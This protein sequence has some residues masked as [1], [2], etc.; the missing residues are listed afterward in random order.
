MRKALIIAFA[1]LAVL[2]GCGSD[3]STTSSGGSGGG[4]PVSL[5]GKTNDHGSKTV[6]GSSIEVEADDFYFGPTFIKAKAGGT[7]TV[8]LKN[9]GGTA[10]NFSIDS[11]K[12]DETLQPGDTM[13]I[14]VQLPSSGALLFYCK[15]H[16]SQGMQGA[17]YSKAG[18][19][20]NAAGASDTGT[21][22]GATTTTADQYGGG[23]N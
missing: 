16:Q 17:I 12:V 10:H 23:Y 22:S 6:S 2:A 5:K 1:A 20:V 21:G 9:E 13:N 3:S 19:S 18:D 11:L 7:V 14:D 8:E 4:A 15:F